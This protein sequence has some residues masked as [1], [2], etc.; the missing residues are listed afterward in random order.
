MANFSLVFFFN[1]WVAT[2]PYPQLPTLTAYSTTTLGGTPDFFF[3][4]NERKRCKTDYLKAQGQQFLFRFY[5]AVKELEGVA[6]TPLVR[7]LC[8]EDCDISNRPTTLHGQ[9]K[10]ILHCYLLN[11]TLLST[12]DSDISVDVTHYTEQNYTALYQLEDCDITD[13][14]I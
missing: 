5:A 3:H 8:I 14:P 6:T 13:R 2:T 4:Q 7:L 12:E 1:S 9:S 10:I 11:I